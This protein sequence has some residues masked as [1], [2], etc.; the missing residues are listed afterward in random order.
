MASELF[1]VIMAGGGGTRL[2]PA[3]RRQSPKQSL[4]LLGDRS[5]FQ[6]AVD[7]VLPVVSPDRI[8]IVTGIDTPRTTASTIRPIVS[9]L[10]SR[11]PPSPRARSTPASGSPA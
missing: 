4:R 9:G 7:R 6:L 1:V 8:L 11:A 3:S 5:L 2:W 10:A